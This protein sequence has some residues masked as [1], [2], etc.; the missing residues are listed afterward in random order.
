MGNDDRHP[1]DQ[2]VA[3][4]C[5]ATTVGPSVGRRYSVATQAVVMDDYDLPAVSDDARANIMAVLT[6]L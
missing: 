3:E 6:D 1:P 5:L 4:L 2:R